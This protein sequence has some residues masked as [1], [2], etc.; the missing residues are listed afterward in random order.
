MECAF[1]KAKDQE[2]DDID[3]KGEIKDRATSHVL[4]ILDKGVG[5]SGLPGLLN[6]S[7]SA[8]FV[9][10]GAAINALNIYKDTV[11]LLAENDVPGFEYREVYIEGEPVRIW[12]DASNEPNDIVVN[13]QL[14]GVSVEPE[15]AALIQKGIEAEVNK[16][17][18][19]ALDGVYNYKAMHGGDEGYAKLLTQ[20][21]EGDD[22][23]N[24]YG[25]KFAEE[26]QANQKRL[27]EIE[28]SQK[29]QPNQNMAGYPAP[30]N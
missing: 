2:C 27:A 24:F 17:Q 28:A 8:I 13:H 11:K 14:M 29:A 5:G 23:M 12:V 10:G 4:G 21:V 26:W 30:G 16:M 19:E 1:K 7:P 6:L 22:I 15:K 3:V 25:V 18:N 9:A 20:L